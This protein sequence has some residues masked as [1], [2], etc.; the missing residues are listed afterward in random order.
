MTTDHGLLQLATLPRVGS[1]NRRP[2]RDECGDRRCRI[3]KPV[4]DVEIIQLLEELAELY[5]IIHGDEEGPEALD[6]EDTEEG[7]QQS[8]SLA[9]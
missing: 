1:I 9:A 7:W 8:E 2:R 6:F 5:E 3:R 4:G